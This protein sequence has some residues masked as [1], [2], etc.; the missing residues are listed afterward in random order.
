[1]RRLATITILALAATGPA[2]ARADVAAFDAAMK[3]LVAEY[4]KIQ[5]ALAGDSSA[6]VAA[7]ARAIASLTAKLDEKGV[8]GK[9]AA[10]Y[11]GLPAKI[12]ASAAALARAKAIAGQREAF[13]QLSAPLAI[14]AKAARPAGIIV[15]HCSMAPGS[16][17]QQGKAIRN[18]YYGAKM[19]ACGEIV[20]PGK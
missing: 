10:H 1:M 6:G 3:P 17:L 14:W 13:K 9:H 4:I 18:P 5:Q 2:T 8:K 11:T 12:K 7:A 20:G 16:W 19:L 15:V